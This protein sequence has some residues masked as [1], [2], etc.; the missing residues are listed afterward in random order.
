[1]TFTLQ[2]RVGEEGRRSPGAGER[3]MSVRGLSAASRCAGNVTPQGFPSRTS[4]GR[5]QPGR[6]E[7]L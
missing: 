3:R 4:A 5:Q 2:E 6:D 1:M 7:A